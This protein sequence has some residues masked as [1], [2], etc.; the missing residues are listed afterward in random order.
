MIAR[1]DIGLANIPIHNI[2][3]TFSYLHGK[4]G[5]GTWLES[6]L[7][8]ATRAEPTDTIWEG[9]IHISIGAWQIFMRFMFSIKRM[10]LKIKSKAL[11]WD[12]FEIILIPG[13]CF[14]QIEF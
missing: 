2:L 11:N 13:Y 3:S 10:P 9:A 8:A 1:D 5:G 7:G 4:G 14:G 12:L 6:S